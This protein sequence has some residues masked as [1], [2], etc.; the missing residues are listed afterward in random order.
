MNS[1]EH[2][3]HIGLSISLL[4]LF[5]LLWF[6]G[7]KS[8]DD[9]THEFV[10]SRLD[11]DIESLLAALE[12]NTDTISLK[13]GKMSPVYQQPFSGHYFVIAINNTP[14]IQ[15]R[16]L[17]DQSLIIPTLKT[18]ERILNV[19]DGPTDQKLLQIS[20][21]F[22]KNGLNISIALAED[23]SA[24]NIQKLKFK[25]YFFIL[26]LIGLVLLLFIQ[27]IILR[28]SFKHLEPVFSNIKYLE[29]GEILKLPENVPSE[30]L[31]LVQEVNHLLILLEKRLERSRNALGN[32]SHALKSPLNLLFQYLH[33]HSDGIDENRHSNLINA[34]KQVERINQLINREL[35]R[36]RIAGKGSSTQRFN[37]LKEIPDLISVVKQI[38][39]HRDLKI[40]VSIDKTVTNFGDREDMLELIGNLLDNACKWANNKINVIVT[41]EIEMDSSQS[42][43]SN[44]INITIEDD[45]SGIE[46]DQLALLTHRG[47]RLDESIDGYGLG[48]S[49]VND[50]VKLYAGTIELTNSST[51]GGM[52]VNITI[53]INL[54]QSTPISMT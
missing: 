14:V 42:I 37:A 52:Q 31:P 20:M 25:K 15:S 2:R 39:S 8:M 32:L 34:K 23:L 22:N 53:D 24:I 6:L 7:Q 29:E 18:G 26:S 33:E 38:Y 9:L 13:K 30:I 5:A 35:K 45:G 12:V 48:L 47:I 43:E 41:R 27:R 21:A 46:E 44:K 54:S 36:G 17:W 3:L 1:L 16:S 11:H 51:L 40:N 49:I 10:G 50:I 28:L 4:L 19:S